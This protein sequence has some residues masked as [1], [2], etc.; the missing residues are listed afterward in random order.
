MGNSGLLVHGLVYVIVQGMVSNRH[1]NR[2]E[3]LM[4]K[5]GSGKPNKRQKMLAYAGRFIWLAAVSGRRFRA[6]CTL[7]QH[8]LCGSETPIKYELALTE[9]AHEKRT[10]TRQP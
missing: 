4:S 3:S 6:V 1:L 9:A 8:Q 10:K 5:T 2:L 7:T